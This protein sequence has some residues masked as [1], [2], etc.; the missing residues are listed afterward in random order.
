[1]ELVTRFDILMRLIT[2]RSNIRPLLA[3]LVIV[4]ILTSPELCRRRRS[5]ESSN[6]NCDLHIDDDRI[7]LATRL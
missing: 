4:S 5:G 3:G 1:M 7:S 6:C 2:Y